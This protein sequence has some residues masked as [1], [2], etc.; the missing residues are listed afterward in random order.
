MTYDAELNLNK[1]INLTLQNYPQSVIV[2]ALAQQADALQ[3]RGESLLPGPTSF[4]AEYISDQVSDNTGNRE[5]NAAFIFP[6]WKWG[7]R[8]AAQGLAELAALD[9]EH[10][11]RALRHQV[12]GLVREALWQMALARSQYQLAKRILEVSDRL[13]ATVKRRVELGDLARS[14]LLLAES[15]RLE[16]RSNLARAEAELMH[17]RRNYINL[18]RLHSA[19]ASFEE[20]KSPLDAI[21]R[22]HPQLAASNIRVERAQANLNWVKSN[23]SGQQPNLYVGTKLERGV[24]GERDLENIDVQIQIPFGGSGYTAPNTAAANLELNQVIAD[25]HAL[26][27]QLEKTLHE[28]EHN[29][30]VDRAELAMATARREIAE[31]YLR[32]SRIGFEAGEI[33]LLDLLRIQAS[34]QA[35]IQKAQQ[36]AILLQRDIARYNQAVGVTP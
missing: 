28:A 16:K 29:I 36:S 18:T 3:R 23:P 1:V 14:D 21:D 31:D 5:I 30:E 2:D 9:T 12:A 15:D 10:Y 6:L 22:R 27:R 26:F 17:A 20:E 19:P 33:N 32:M 8:D 13:V 35:A 11:Q 25:R 24:R 34:A 4:F 7:Q